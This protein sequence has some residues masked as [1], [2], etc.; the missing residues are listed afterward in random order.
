MLLLSV[1][2]NNDKLN[3]LENVTTEKINYY[4][5][6]NSS[7][8]EQITVS[9]TNSTDEVYH[10]Y[11]FDFDPDKYYTTSELIEGLTDEDK[12]THDIKFDN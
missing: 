9:E 5:F 2:N 11:S 8:N 4:D 3:Y 6:T 1:C 10:E 7:T 12:K